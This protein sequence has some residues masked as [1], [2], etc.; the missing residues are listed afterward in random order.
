MVRI[1]VK[2]TVG[3]LPQRDNQIQITTLKTVLPVCLQDDS[4]AEVLVSIPPV[5]WTRSRAAST[6]NAVNHTILKTIKDMNL[7]FLKNSEM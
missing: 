4:R 5:T 6:Q 7:A 2:K 3:R 1:D